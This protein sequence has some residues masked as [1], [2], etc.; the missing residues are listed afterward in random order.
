MTQTA[1]LPTSRT[2]WTWVLMLALML[3][4]AASTTAA[5]QPTGVQ[6]RVIAISKKPAAMSSGQFRTAAL[7]S[8]ARERWGSRLYH[9]SKLKK[10]VN[11]VP[12]C[13]GYPVEA[14]AML[15]AVTLGTLDKVFHRGQP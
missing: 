7:V 15:T 14:G 11:A 4:T 8:P 13:I 3:A 1:K 2:K 9:S 10:F 12:R 6:P 5:A